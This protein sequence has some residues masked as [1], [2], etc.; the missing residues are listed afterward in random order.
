M[1]HPIVL[2]PMLISAVI[3]RRWTIPFIA[4]GSALVF[5]PGWDAIG[6]PLYLAA[7]GALTG[8]PVRWGLAELIRELNP[9]R[10]RAEQ[11]WHG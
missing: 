8:L 3:G 9:R 7:L 4:L 5:Y 1:F 2:L 11:E 6:M 10:N